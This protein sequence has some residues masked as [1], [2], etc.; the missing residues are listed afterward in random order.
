MSILSFNRLTLELKTLRYNRFVLL[1][2][3]PLSL[4]NLIKQLLDSIVIVHLRIR[5]NKTKLTDPPQPTL[6]SKKARTGG[7]G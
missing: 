6:A 1:E 5:P 4:K 3:G 2:I 7:S